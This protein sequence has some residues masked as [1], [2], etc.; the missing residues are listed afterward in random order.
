MA[1]IKIE[2]PIDQQVKELL[3]AK[4]QQI[5]RAMRSA[6][7]TAAENILERGRAD[8][9]A[10]GKF[11]PR[12][13]SGLT[14]PVTEEQAGIVI[15]VQESAPFW[16]VFQYGAVIQGKPLLYFAPDR[17]IFYR[18][19]T[20]TPAVISKYQVQIPKKF[21]LVE[22]IQDV[23]KTIGALYRVTFASGQS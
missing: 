20:T 23:S 11:G 5:K 6:A 2:P 19:K 8:I 7:E 1:S 13:T 12:W 16:Q 15:T 22:I 3:D 21:H 10:A 9:A 17:P 4:A 18:G 14:A